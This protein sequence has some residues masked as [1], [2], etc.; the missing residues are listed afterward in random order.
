MRSIATSKYG[1]DAASEDANLKIARWR[2]QL[3]SFLN[4]QVSSKALI[5]RRL[6][7]CTLAHW[8]TTVKS[9]IVPDNPAVKPTAAPDNSTVKPTT[10]PD[11]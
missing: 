10:A 5:L 6:T 3:F 2:L 7:S 8:S 9:T 4:S 1:E 11:N